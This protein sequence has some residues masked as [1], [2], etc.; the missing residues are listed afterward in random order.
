MK[1][2]LPFILVLV[3][4]GAIAYFVFPAVNQQSPESAKSYE[5]YVKACIGA[6]EEEFTCRCQANILRDKLE[7]A[8]ID[9]LTEVGKAVEKNDMETVSR[10]QAAN[11]EI[12]KALEDMPDD[13]GNCVLE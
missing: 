3:V 8:Q 2:I 9:L 5:N 4:V 10:I 11:P 6:G 7:P 1:K 12:F 13:V